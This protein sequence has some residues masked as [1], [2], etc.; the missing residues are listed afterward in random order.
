MTELF[1][2][3]IKEATKTTEDDSILGA[4][5]RRIMQEELALEAMQAYDANPNPRQ[6]TLDQM[7]TEIKQEKE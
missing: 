6:Y 5:V 2:N 1:Y 4:T 3:R 7:I